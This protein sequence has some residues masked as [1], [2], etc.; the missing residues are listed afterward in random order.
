MSVKIVYLESD[1][2]YS[3]TFTEALSEIIN[4]ML[5]TYDLS[6]G[7]VSVIIG[8]N[9]LLQNLN[10][11]YRNKDAATDVLSFSYLDS[12]DQHTPFEEVSIGDI[13]I[14]IEKARE[15]SEEAG[16]SLKKETALLIIHG[17]LHLMG[18]N[19]D[20]DAEAEQMQNIEQKLLDKFDHAV[21]GGETDA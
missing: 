8:D 10:R 1:D 19:H 21:T 16:H 7:E 11:Q 18:F 13:Y 4:G 3:E 6:G 14:S 20:D 17:M 2:T 5:D 15:N 12:Q 9:K